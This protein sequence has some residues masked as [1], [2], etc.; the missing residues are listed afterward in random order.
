[1]CLKK[2]KSIWEE[3]L[4]QVQ[5]TALFKQQERQLHRNPQLKKQKPDFINE[6]SSLG[7]TEVI[8]EI[9]TRKPQRNVYHLQHQ[10]YSKILLRPS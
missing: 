4:S 9:E 1:M 3:R 6:F 2:E 7:H 8:P 5:H 10:C